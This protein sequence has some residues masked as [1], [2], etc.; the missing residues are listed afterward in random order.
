MLRFC[1]AAAFVPCLS[2]TCSLGLPPPSLRDGGPLVKR[3]YLID[4]KVKGADG[5]LKKRLLIDLL[6]IDDPRDIGGPLPTLPATKFNM[7]FD[8]IE[9]ILPLGAHTL[10]VA[11]DTNFPGED[12]REKGVPDSTEFIKLEF[13]RPLASYA[14]KGEDCD[15]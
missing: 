5:V 8:S 13:K 4:L 6:D 3:L 11:I 14:P 15:R 12:G 7:P 2:F 1:G 10:A 9:C